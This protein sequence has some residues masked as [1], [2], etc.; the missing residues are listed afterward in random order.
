MW[1]FYDGVSTS[2]DP[3]VASTYVFNSS[4]FTV[5]NSALGGTNG[6]ST[7]IVVNKTLQGVTAADGS[8]ITSIDCSTSSLPAATCA[9]FNKYK[10]AEW[11][12]F[13]VGTTGTQPGSVPFAITMSVDPAIYPLPSGVNKN[14]L[15]VYHTYTTTSGTVE[16]IISG[17]CAGQN[18]TLPCL[19]SVTVSK[20]LIQV[21]FLTEHNG[22]GGMY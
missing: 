21:T 16:E 17:A 22:K 2:S 14:N 9:Q 11:S 7:K 13:T 3:N 19:S 5:A 6:Q 8:P 18:P 15:A 10:F 1:N 4:Q 12:E 20:T